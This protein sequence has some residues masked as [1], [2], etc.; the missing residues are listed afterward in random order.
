MLQ[1]A[2]QQRVDLAGVGLAGVGRRRR[3]DDGELA[4][5]FGAVRHRPAPAPQGRRAGPPRAAW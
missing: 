4:A 5:N 2:P 3:D 1:G